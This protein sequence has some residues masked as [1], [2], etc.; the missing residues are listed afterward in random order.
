[1]SQCESHRARCVPSCLQDAQPFRPPQASDLLEEALP[2]QGRATCCT[3]STCSIVTSPKSILTD[4][5]RIKSGQRAVHP[6]T[7]SSRR[8]GL[9]I[10]GGFR[11]SWYSLLCGVSP[12]FVLLGSLYMNSHIAGKIKFW[13]CFVFFLEMTLNILLFLVQIKCHFKSI[14]L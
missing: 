9:T 4:A 8:T 7:Q 11:F 14:L 12:G 6:V 1:M 3:Q 10:T 5:L 2:P 13:F